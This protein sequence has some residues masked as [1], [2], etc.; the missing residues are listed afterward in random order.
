MFALCCRH[1]VE[2]ILIPDRH[3][4]KGKGDFALVD[5]REKWESLLLAE[6]EPTQQELVRTLD[7]LDK[8]LPSLRSKL[9][10]GVK[11]LPHRAGR[12]KLL[13]DPK[14]QQEVIEQVKYIRGPGV[15][16]SDAFKR[17]ALKHNVSN[18]TIKRIW[19]DHAEVS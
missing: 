7:R 13:D 1:H 2:S 15:K 17:V 18:S 6:P 11:D 10:G 12:R 8:V 14:K 9:K 19:R 4:L 16:L 5:T 3:E